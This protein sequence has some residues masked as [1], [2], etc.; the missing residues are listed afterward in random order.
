MDR[1][2]NT[3]NSFNVSLY[4]TD[5][6]PFGYFCSSDC[7]WYITHKI[8]RN[9]LLLDEF[10]GWGSKGWALT[11]WALGDSLTPLLLFSQ[12][13]DRLQKYRA[14]RPAPLLDSTQGLAQDVSSPLGHLVFFV[15]RPEWSDNPAELGRDSVAGP[16]VCL[17]LS[18]WSVLEGITIVN[19]PESHKY[20]CCTCSLTDTHLFIV[21]FFF[22]EIIWQLLSPK[23]HFCV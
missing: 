9:I 20:M 7:M 11:L 8:Q 1:Q 15:S 21:L 3:Q 4:L 23:L 14:Q 17:V 22:N 6:L 18:V 19:T 2:I 12:V 10:Q 13:Y 5:I 16:L